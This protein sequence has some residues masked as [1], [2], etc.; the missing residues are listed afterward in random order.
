MANLIEIAHKSHGK[1]AFS[2]ARIEFHKDSIHFENALNLVCDSCR[3]DGGGNSLDD[4]PARRTQVLSDL[5][6][7]DVLENLSEVFNFLYLACSSSQFDLTI[8]NF[9]DVLCDLVPKDT[10]E[11]LNYR[12][13]IKSFK[14][15]SSDFF[16]AAQ[17]KKWIDETQE[18]M[19]QCSTMVQAQFYYSHGLYL[20]KTTFN[21]AKYQKLPTEKFKEAARL[22][23]AGL[24]KDPQNATL[25]LILHYS[26]M[27]L[28][29]Q[30]TKCKDET[31]I[32]GG[33]NELIKVRFFCQTQMCIMSCLMPS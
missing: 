6:T 23:E 33:K 31:R 20:A 10:E 8:F 25:K 24:E 18:E 1:D 14:I 7:S 22:S 28:A 2:E 27:S 29:I 11:G 17:L 26:M 30:N 4:L 5:R 3:D 16:S 32:D 15:R 19:K 9:L 21:A 12:I 13:L